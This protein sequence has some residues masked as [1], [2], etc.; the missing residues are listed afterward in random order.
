M[1]VMGSRRLLCRFTSMGLVV[2]RILFLCLLL[3]SA[4]GAPLPASAAPTKIYNGSTLVWLSTKPNACQ[5]RARSVVFVPS[6][7]AINLPSNL[8]VRGVPQAGLLAAQRLK[9]DARKRLVRAT[10][11]AARAKAQR[12]ITEAQRLIQS[13]KECRTAKLPPDETPTPTAT[14]TS[15]A[16]PTATPTPTQTP[17]AARALSQ[18]TSVDFYGS[19]FMVTYYIISQGAT[20][21]GEAAQVIVEPKDSSAHYANVRVYDPQENLLVLQQQERGSDESAIHYYSPTNSQVLPASSFVLAKSGIYE[22]RVAGN[23]NVRVRLKLPADVGW[24][25]SFQNG[26]YRPFVGAQPTMYTWIPSHPTRSLKL[27]IAFGQYASDLSIPGLP[28]TPVYATDTTTIIQND[29]VIPASSEG[30]SVQPV[31]MPSSPYSE[32]SAWGLPFILSRTPSEANAIR[33]GLERV[34][35]GST[36]GYLIA[37]PFQQKIAELLPE[38]TARAGDSAALFAASGSGFPATRMECTNPVKNEDVIRNIEILDAYQNTLPAAK[39]LL[40]S[41]NGKPN[42]ELSATSPWIGTLGTSQ[43]GRQYCAVSADCAN[44]STC[45]AGLCALPFDPQL[46][47]W[48]R[49]QPIEYQQKVGSV[50]ETLWFGRSIRAQYHYALVWAATTYSPCN[51]YGPAAPGGSIRFPELLYR[52]VAGAL[53]DLMTVAES[54]Q[55]YGQNGT[56]S[57]PYPGLV[58][59]VLEGVMPTFQVAAPYLTGVMSSP[60]GSPALGQ[61]VLDTWTAALERLI[62]RHINDYLASSQ[63]QSAHHL[64]SFQSFANG[65]QD[66]AKRAFYQALVRRWAGRFWESLRP[67]GYFRENTAICGSYSGITTNMIGRYL[68]LAAQSDLGTDYEGEY[69]L[70]SVYMLFNHTVA[71]EP[72][73][74]LVGGFN[75]NHRIGN[76]F[77]RTQYGGASNLADYLPEVGVWARGLTASSPANRSRL[78]STAQAFETRV[79][80]TPNAPAP[81]IPDRFNVNAVYGDPTLQFPVEESTRFTKNFGNEYI[82][83][84]RPGYFTGIF[85]GKP[86]AGLGNLKYRD[87]YRTPTTETQLN[88]GGTSVEDLP[89]ESGASIS[90]YNYNPYLGGGMSLF[91]TPSYG[92]ALVGT[93]WSALAQHGLVAWDGGRRYWND[94]FSTTYALS[95][96]NNTLTVQGTIEAHPLSYTRQYIFNDHSVRVN[97]ALTATADMTLEKLA[98]IIPVPTCTRTDCNGSTKNRKSRG[99]DLQIQG[100]VGS[101]NGALRTASAVTVKDSTNRGVQISFVSPTSDAST[102]QAVAVYR[103]G[104]RQLYYGAELQVGRIEVLLP[105]TWSAGDELNLSYTIGALGSP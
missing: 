11:S 45:S 67:A 36:D 96:D 72:D 76:G 56:V 16:T 31:V 73:G 103:N 98:E 55:F 44:G 75:F 6:S 77:E 80:N 54:E 100:A 13:N 81:G 35:G 105:Q 49:F 48:D 22:V 32:F 34:R 69:A 70:R 17:F 89:P 14:P 2:S 43:Y 92:A 7:T 50:R 62:N 64:V 86:A 82:A 78:L 91:W 79:T 18:E 29:Y 88:V 30:G 58:G 99:A 102:T 24:G 97:L 74:A 46:D 85:V 25:V 104:L 5:V 41:A 95:Q 12:S 60:T 4:L 53:S 59:F 93:T 10:S 39:W 23:T 37:H 21:S 84:R 47:R 52:G 63:N 28:A 68:G 42:Q 94:Y 38:L 3:A 1:R 90:V 51:P 26:T 65:V 33:A 101:D 40:G 9:T 71:P 87:N 15:T 66:P 27:S 20:R 57:S 19:T 61:R 8:R 83:V